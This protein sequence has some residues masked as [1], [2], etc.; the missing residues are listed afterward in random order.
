MRSRT[1]FGMSTYVSVEISPATTTSPV[2]ISVSQA[3]R[4][5]SSSLNTAS[6]TASE[7]WSAIL[8][9][10]PSVTDSEVKRNSRAA[11]AGKATRRP[12]RRR[13][14]DPQEEGDLHLARLHGRVFDR[15]TERL[16]VPLDL[17]RN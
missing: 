1:S 14:L 7:T 8:S 5:C 2:V 15:G 16:Q 3:Q 13:S 4:A 9:G 11:T 12:H 10:W 17:A 6:S